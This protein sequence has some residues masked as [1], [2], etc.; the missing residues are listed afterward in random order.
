MKKTGFTLTEIL[1]V[2][3]I[4]SMV[5]AISLPAISKARNKAAIM[6]TKSMI[7]SIESALFMYQTDMGDYPI[8][9]GST[10]ILIFAL[11]GPLDDENW[12]GPYMRFKESDIDENNN[13][14][15][16]WRNPLTYQYPQ[17]EKT[18]VPF[19]IVS[20]GPDR[21]PD[22]QDDIGNWK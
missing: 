15:D 8:S 12:K 22:T 10:E 5:A 18:N 16:V 20:K 19:I 4:I 3:V 1:V 13:I 9:T 11:M 7:A 14:V 21:K 6:K 17:H 2:L